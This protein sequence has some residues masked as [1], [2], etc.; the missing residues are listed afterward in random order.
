MQTVLN[1]SKTHKLTL[2]KTAGQWWLELIERA[3]GLTRIVYFKRK[4]KALAFCDRMTM[5]GIVRVFIEVLKIE[6]V[7]MY[8]ENI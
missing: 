1:E 2:E 3:T 5:P 7:K 6:P 4:D 8:K